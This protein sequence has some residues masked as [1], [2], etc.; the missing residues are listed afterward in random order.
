GNWNRCR[1]Q[2]IWVFRRTRR[3]AMR[4]TDKVVLRLRSLFRRREIEQELDDE[5]RFHVEQ[6]IAENIA[7]GMA[8]D[9]ARYAARRTIGGLAQIQEECRDTR[10]VNTVV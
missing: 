5:L 3:E 6:Q 1:A 4:W 7:V 9:D 2:S 8:P 10:G